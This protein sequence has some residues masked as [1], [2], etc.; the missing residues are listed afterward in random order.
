MMKVLMENWRRYLHEAKPS[1][2]KSR[3][4]TL[5][6]KYPDSFNVYFDW[7]IY[8]RKDAVAKEYARAWHERLELLSQIEGR[9]YKT[10]QDGSQWLSMYDFFEDRYKDADE[11]KENLKSLQRLFKQTYK[12][13]M[14]IRLEF[15][16]DVFIEEDCPQKL[17]LLS[18]LPSAFVY[19]PDMYK[20]GLAGSAQDISE[21]VD[22]DGP[23]PYQ[24]CAELTGIEATA[25][26]GAEAEIGEF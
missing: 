11:L 17:K 21:D 18:Y 19:H 2:E 14:D 22:I 16:Y 12:H 23:T 15:P 9:V 10:R 25:A 8:E 7:L 26:A 20:P 24:E 6:S 5:L 3:R 13:L 4:S 1:V